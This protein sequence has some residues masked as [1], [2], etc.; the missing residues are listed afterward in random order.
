[1]HFSGKELFYCQHVLGSVSMH[2]TRNNNHSLTYKGHNRP[3]YVSP[4]KLFWVDLRVVNPSF[5]K[6]DFNPLYHIAKLRFLS[7]LQ[8]VQ[9]WFWSDGVPDTAFS[10]YTEWM[11]ECHM[12]VRSWVT[13]VTLVH[14]LYGLIWWQEQHRQIFPCKHRRSFHCSKRRRNHKHWE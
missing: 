5:S 4:L 7:H 3:V 10:S 8:W 2:L 6:Q 14:S 1:M 13:G 11:S 12:F 9:S